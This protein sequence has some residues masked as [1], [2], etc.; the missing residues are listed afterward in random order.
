MKTTLSTF[1]LALIAC[2]SFAQLA[3]ELEPFYHGV[4]S[5]DPTTDRVILWTKV[6]PDGTVNP[7]DPIPVLWRIATDTAMTNIVNNGAGNALQSKDY[8]FKIDA[9]G[10]TPGA[11]YFY[12][13]YALGKYSLRGRTFTA[14][15][16]DIDSLRFAVASSASYEHGYFNI[17][18]HLL[19]RN[20]FEAVIHLGNY[21]YEYGAGENTAGIAGRD[22]TPANEIISIADYRDRHAHYKLDADLRLLHQQYPFITVWNDHESA[23]DAYN[24]GAQ[25]HTEGA[26]GTWVDRKANAQQVYH[27]YMPIRTTMGSTS[28]Y[29]EL[30][31]GDLLNFFMLDTRLEDKPQPDWNLANDPNRSILGATQFDWLTAGLRNSATQWNVLGQQMRMSPFDIN[32]LPFGQQYGDA[33]QW[34]GYAAERTKLYDS[35]FANNIQNMVV[36]SGDLGGSWADDLPTATYNSS[37]GAGSAGVEFGVPSVTAPTSSAA[38]STGAPVLLSTNSQLKYAELSKLGYII[39]DVNKIRTQSDWYHID[40]VVVNTSNET[41]ASGWF[42]NDGSRHLTQA[43]GPSVASNQYGKTFAPALPIVAN[44]NSYDTLTVGACSSYTSPSGNY[45]WTTSNTYAD[46]I[47]NTIGGDSILTINL[48]VTTINVSV[49]QVQEVLTADAGSS[50]YQWLNC[51]SLTAISG[52]TNQ[53]YTA[54]ANGDYAVIVSN[55]GC[56]DTSACFTVSTIGIVENSFG[57]AFNVYPNPTNGDFSIDLGANFETATVNLTNLNGQLIRSVNYS[58][59]QLL[60]MTLTEPTGVYLLIVESGEFKAVI[61]LVKD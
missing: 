9:T 11:C 35:I 47:P 2:S 59:S 20:D 12:D 56:S 57:N 51:P 36:L 30:Q 53:S 42:T 24:D 44:F 34:D 55:N 4:A 52:A 46:T 43:G 28:S 3:P 61:R 48:T 58:D 45:V 60:N 1:L 7:G 6:T 49:T 38:S 18:K 37:T 54:T 8:T 17:Y 10:L 40:S 21:I 41:F 26:E 15:T 33:S 23:N 31:Y 50:S 19:E 32:P 16:G 5:G 39:L 13:F 14:P 25:N 27:E 22:Y 29:R